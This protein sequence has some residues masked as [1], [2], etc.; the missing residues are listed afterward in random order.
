[1][2]DAVRPNDTPLNYEISGGISRIFAETAEMLS[3]LWTEQFGVDVD[4]GLEPGKVRSFR[5][6]AYAQQPPFNLVQIR[7]RTDHTNWWLAIPSSSASA[8][9]DLLLGSMHADWDPLD[10]SLNSIETE[11]LMSLLAQVN[12]SL[13]MQWR[14]VTELDLSVF[15]WHHELSEIEADLQELLDVDVVCLKWRLTIG[16]HQSQLSLCLPVN[17]ILA[18]S[19]KL[20]QHHYGELPLEPH[21]QA[22]VQLEVEAV[23]LADL[24]VGEVLETGHSLDNPLTLELS[25][26]DLHQVRLGAKEGMKAIQVVE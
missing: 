20:V 3:A 4:L 25:N 17:F 13:E 9:L 6:F 15:Q 12:Q 2:Q 18:W 21:Y 22:T 16:K 7:N 23:N 19:K 5:Q 10:R 8:L 11:L 1:M 26:G 24:Q 14:P